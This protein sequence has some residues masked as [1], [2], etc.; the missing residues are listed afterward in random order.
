MKIF[1]SL[2]FIL[3]IAVPASASDIDWKPYS[4]DVFAQ[5]R[6]DHKLV[7]LDLQAVWCHWCHVMDY[8]T[9]SKPQI[10]KLIG[11]NFLAIKVDQDSRPDISNRYEDYG[12][13][14]TIVFDFNGHEI[15]KRRGYLPPEEMESMLKAVIADPTPG[16]SIQPAQEIH[17]TTQPALSPMLNERLKVDLLSYYDDRQGGWGRGYKFI[18]AD[19]IEYCTVQAMTGDKR[20]EQMVRQTLTAGLKII[21]P[22]WGGVYQYSTD[23]DWIHPHFE[24]IMSY[25]TDDMRT[26]ARSYAVWHDPAYLSAA[27]SIHHF[28]QTFM[29]SPQGAF[30]TS[31]DADLHDGEHAGE[32]F[33]LDDAQRR[34]Q[35]IP[36]IDTHIY[37]RENGWAISSLVALHNFTGDADALAEAK[38]AALWII[39]NRSIDGRGYCHDEKDSA[40]PYL[41]DTLAIGRAFLDLYAATADRIWLDRANEAGIFIREN[42]VDPKSPGLLTFKA[43]AGESFPPKPEADENIAAARFARMLFEYTGADPHQQLAER[44]MRYAA[45]PE[46][47]GNRSWL[48]GGLLLANQEMGTDPFHIVI[49]GPKTDTLAASLFDLA[50]QSPLHFKRLEWYDRTQGPLTRMDV[51]YPE[52]KKSTAFVCNS[53]ACSYPISDAKKLEQKLVA[54]SSGK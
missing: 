4:D 27:Q 8:Q 10:Q 41:G 40:G 52:L 34:Q 53:S 29:R 18:D 31:Q 16:P 30:Y 7:I 45:S 12:W 32:F 5:A 3:L 46:I 33:A 50:A 39:N 6:R 47:A 17:A 21:D 38:T 25:Q 28:L 13:P 22:A 35:G 24:K 36:R 19:L 11:D 43:R 14:A 26:Y 51:E 42:F 48:V 44:A 2:L 20:A 1:C 9:Y 37:S 15:V 23:A 49:V 54:L